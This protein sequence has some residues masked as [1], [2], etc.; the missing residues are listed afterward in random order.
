[1]LC[2]N[3]VYLGLAEYIQVCT[4]YIMEY[5]SIQLY[6]Q[7]YFLTNFILRYASVQLQLYN[8]NCPVC[9][10][11]LSKDT[12]V[13]HANKS[14]ARLIHQH[15]SRQQPIARYPQKA[16]TYITDSFDRTA[17]AS[18]RYTLAYLRISPRESRGAGISQDKSPRKSGRGGLTQ[19]LYR[20]VY[21]EIYCVQTRIYQYIKVYTSIYRYISVYTGISWYIPRGYIPRA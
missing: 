11:Q 18:C 21:T 2:D 14:I 20:P 15:N 8:R 6:T 9:M 3:S 10:C 1:M 17:P 7:L 5:T 19:G 4:W 16:D 12:E 13:N